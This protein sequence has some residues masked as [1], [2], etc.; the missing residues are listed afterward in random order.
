MKQIIRTTLAHNFEVDDIY[1]NILNN[2]AA[3]TCKGV[4][5][6]QYVNEY[7]GDVTIP[8]IVT[9][10]GTLHVPVGS[11]EAYQVDENWYPYFGQI[12]EMDLKGDANIDGVFNIGDITDT[13]D[14]LL[15]KEVAPFSDAGADLNGNGRVDLGDLVDLI[16]L[17][18]N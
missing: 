13:I 18:L 9:Y 8:A 14:Y 4:S 3:V 16:D 7:F 1:Y 2:E 17:L 11:V 10:N 15:G 6:I 12:V 5:Y